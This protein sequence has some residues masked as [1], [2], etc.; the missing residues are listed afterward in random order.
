MSGTAAGSGGGSAQVRRLN[1]TQ[2]PTERHQGGSQSRRLP[3]VPVAGIRGFLSGMPSGRSPG[4]GPE[5][6]REGSG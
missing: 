6:R 3:W 1:C 4:A 2:N 5:G